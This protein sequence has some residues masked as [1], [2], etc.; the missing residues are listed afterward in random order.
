VTQGRTGFPRFGGR[1]AGPLYRHVQQDLGARIRRGDLPV[2]SLVPSEHQIC[3]QYGVSMTTAR[4]ALLELTRQGLIYRH[5]GL[6]SFVADP[7]R[8][9]RLGLVF[10][11]FDSAR[12]RNGSFSIGELVGGVTEVVWRHECALDLT[13]VDEPLGTDVLNRLI[14]QGGIHGL[15]LRTLQNVEDDLVDFLERAAFPYV[16][17]RRYHPTRPVNAVASDDAVGVRLAVTHLAG[18]GHRRIALISA[19]PDMVL[20]RDR[21]RGYLAAVAA[22]RLERDDGLIRLADYYTTDLAHD[23]TVEL[24]SRP[25]FQRPSAVIVDA[26]MAPGVY[27]AAAELGV[28][29]PDDLGVVGYDDTPAARSLTPRLTQV[30]TS[31]FEIGQAA[32]EALLDLILGRVHGPRQ[33]FVEPVLE[34]HA[35]SGAGAKKGGIFSAAG[36]ERGRGQ[37]PDR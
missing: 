26:A 5:A 9:K 1:P 11:G 20:T 35:S 33:V 18:L 8:N 21:V 19:L 12:W 28:T 36:R 4:R 22:H 30:C 23:L 31:H 6:G 37:A 13:R 14:T 15:L 25:P 29:I 27:E 7:G 24:L 2:G 17:V 3:A 32:A 16:F 34:V 10:A